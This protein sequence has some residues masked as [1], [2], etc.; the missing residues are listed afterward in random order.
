MRLSEIVAHKNIIDHLTVSD[1]AE[2][3]SLGL[4][5]IVEIIKRTQLS[6]DEQLEDLDTSKF[7][8]DNVLI[9]Y[10]TIIES[11]Q[12][13]ALRVIETHEEAYFEQSKSLY[14]N[15]QH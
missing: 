13:A 7:V 14:E 9:N 12:V 10:E 11:I 1:I 15:M 6:V 5:R 2:N 4:E 8:I 3:I